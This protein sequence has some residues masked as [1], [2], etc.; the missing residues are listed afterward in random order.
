MKSNHRFILLSKFLFNFEYLSPLLSSLQ[1]LWQAA[2]VNTSEE[3]LRDVRTPL[4]LTKYSF[5]RK[6][7]V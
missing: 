2:V 1:V 5:N 6:I 4:F 3:L 7:P